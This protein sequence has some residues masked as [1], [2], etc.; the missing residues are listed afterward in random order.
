MSGICETPLGIPK[1]KGEKHDSV[2]V[3]LSKIIFDGSDEW[4]TSVR[5]GAL[6]RFQLSPR[7]ARIYGGIKTPT[8]FFS[9]NFKSSNS[10]A[11]LEHHTDNVGAGGSNPSLT[12]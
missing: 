8:L 12:T 7:D 3:F 1:R 10:S 9:I 2:K 5:F 6:V 4:V 11:R